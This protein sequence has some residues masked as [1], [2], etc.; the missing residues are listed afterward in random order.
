[1]LTPENC[2]AQAV[3]FVMV[4][5]D[6]WVSITNL[7]TALSIIHQ[8]SCHRTQNQVTPIRVWMARSAY[9]MITFLL[10]KL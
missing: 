5:N 4:G 1:M 2:P 7:N 8:Y 10:L 6:S 3:P 9:F